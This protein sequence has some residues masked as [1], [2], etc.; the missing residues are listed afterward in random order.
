M[1]HAFIQ[2][3][4]KGLA[5]ATEDSQP[6]RQAGVGELSKRV[7]FCTGG[8]ATV[9]RDVDGQQGQVTGSSLE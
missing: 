1:L 3:G 9:S 2:L 7:S 4:R 8:R 6:E 5:V